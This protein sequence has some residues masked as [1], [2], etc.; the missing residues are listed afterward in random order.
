MSKQNFV[1]WA[2]YLQS[3]RT[4]NC[5]CI[6]TI[7]WFHVFQSNKFVLSHSSTRYESDELR[8]HDLTVA[9]LSQSL[10]QRKIWWYPMMHFDILLITRNRALE[11]MLVAVEAWQFSGAKDE[12][13]WVWSQGGVGRPNTKEKK[14]SVLCVGMYCN[15]ASNWAAC[16]RSRI[17]NQNAHLD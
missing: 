2:Y 14:F 15:V 13:M 6:K 10:H 11:N 3:D 17:V 1:Q 16:D 8:M 7:C 4:P 12:E 9:N 5:N